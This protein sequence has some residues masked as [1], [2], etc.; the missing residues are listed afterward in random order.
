MNG[1]QKKFLFKI[2]NIGCMA[3]ILGGIVFVKCQFL[4]RWVL[5]MSPI[6]VIQ[7]VIFLKPSK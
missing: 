7:L 2:K 4:I 1:I 3:Q 5:N 6:S